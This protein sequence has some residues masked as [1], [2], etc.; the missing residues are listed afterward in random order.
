MGG[1][2][3]ILEMDSGDGFAQ[4]MNILNTT[5]ED[6]RVLK[7][8]C[9]HYRYCQDPQTHKVAIASIGKRFTLEIHMLLFLFCFVFTEDC[10]ILIF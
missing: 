10:L 8:V 2:E 9:F 3:T 5:E 6:L 4:H 1:D 7:M